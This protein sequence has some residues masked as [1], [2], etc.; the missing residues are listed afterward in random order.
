MH[1]VSKAG[2]AVTARRVVSVTKERGGYI[3]KWDDGQT[4]RRTDDFYYNEIHSYYP[5]NFQV[6]INGEVVWMTSETFA[7]LFAKDE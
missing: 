2:L 6:N 5:D 1:Y 3:I 4:I 7:L